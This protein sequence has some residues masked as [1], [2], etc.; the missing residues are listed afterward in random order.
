MVG[1]IAHSKTGAAPHSR[2]LVSK[3]QQQEVEQSSLALQCP[4]QGHAVLKQVSQ[5]PISTGSHRILWVAQKA[6]Q[7]PI[8]FIRTSQK[9]LDE[10]QVAGRQNPGCVGQKG[11]KVRGQQRLVTQEGN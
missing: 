5:E 6:A 3:P 4:T 7:G 11:E 10:G 9:F 2:V 1:C 8:G